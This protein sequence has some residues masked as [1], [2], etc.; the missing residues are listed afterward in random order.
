MTVHRQSAQMALREMTLNDSQLLNTAKWH[1]ALT[2][3]T[4]SILKCYAACHFSENNEVTADFVHTQ[5]F[6]SLKSVSK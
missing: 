4:C 6:C 5:R 3:V 2:K 1:S